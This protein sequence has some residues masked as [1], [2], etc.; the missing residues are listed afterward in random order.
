M[1]Y[2][3]FLTLSLFVAAGVV[4]ADSPSPPSS[5]SSKRA[6]IDTHVHYDQDIWES[7]PPQSAIEA[8]RELGIQRAWVSSTPDEGT[9]RL[10][11]AAPEFVV[12][13]LRPYRYAGHVDTWAHDETIIDD[14]KQRL[15]QHRYAAIGEFHLMGDEARSP[16]VREVVALAQQH[17]LILHVHSDARSIEILYQ[18]NPDALILWAHAGFEKSDVVKRM[19]DTYPTLWADLS[20]RRNIFPDGKFVDAWREL[21]IEHADRFTLGVDT[22]AVQIWMFVE[23]VVSWERAL[24][25]S[26]PDEVAT[27]I[28][29]DNAEVLLSHSGWDKTD[30]RK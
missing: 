23:K 5:T 29:S 1:R 21:L 7:I 12:P 10:Y 24:L 4:Q 18:I 20:E 2:A 14:L 13:V 9:R 28:A 22:W 16:V 27:R 17:Q 8:L 11:A 26:L 25:A 15:K 6:L 19:L 30:K 3:I